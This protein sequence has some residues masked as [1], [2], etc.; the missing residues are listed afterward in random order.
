[1]MADYEL[2]PLSSVTTAIK[3][4][5]H[6]THRRVRDG[7]PLLSAKNISK[8]GSI[9]W[10]DSDDRISESEY[11]QI[12]SSFELEAGDLLLTIVG[13]LGRRA[14][15]EGQKVTFQRSVAYI[16]PDANRV[17]TGYLF[18]WAAHPRFTE[19]LTRRSNATAQAGLYLKELAQVAVP[20]CPGDSQEMIAAVLGTVD[21]A[22][23][24]TAAIIDKLKQVKQGLL[25]DLLTRGIDENGNLRP[26]QLE[27]PQVY[28]QSPLGWI[29][30]AWDVS[31]IGTVVQSVTSGSRGWAAYYAASGA[32]FVRSQNVRMGYLD[33]TDRQY[34][35][36]PM[37][38][39]GVRTRLAPNDLLITITGN[40]VGNVSA[41]PRS[42]SETAFVS[43]HVGLVRF[44]DPK[45]AIFAMHYLVKGSP[46]NRQLMDAQYGQSKPGLNL[47]NLRA[48]WV[49]VPSTDEQSQIVERIENAHGRIGVENQFATGLRA[50]K[51]G[52]M[53]D[54]LTGR[55]RVTSLLKEQR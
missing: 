30:E 3:D 5:T 29:P 39:E 40:S 54:L 17:S 47:E 36:P 43:Q 25:H 9:V 26:P 13:S 15:Y 45:L 32:L 38:S 2:Q 7:V 48:L 55:V 10:D 16:R 53:D 41:V 35:S 51:S 19:E 31:Q 37:G 11:R 14:I 33:F 24:Q 27:A 28:K 22:I 18:H 34:V 49:P 1:M 44:H 42:W 50:L 4:G 20:I 52:L 6:G 23:R 8:A 12:H 21:A 46:G